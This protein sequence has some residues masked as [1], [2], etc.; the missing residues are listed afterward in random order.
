M[1]ICKADEKLSLKRFVKRGLE[2]PMREYFHGDKGVELARRGVKLEINPYDEP[3]LV[4]VPTIH[5]DTTG[6]YNPSINELKT[7]IFG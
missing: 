6:A 2:N 1:L 4:D 5:V 7:I 3:H